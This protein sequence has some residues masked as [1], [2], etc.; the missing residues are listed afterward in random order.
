MR[1][2]AGTNLL[3]SYEPAIHILLVR[4]AHEVGTDVRMNFEAVS[5][6]DALLRERHHLHD[7]E[8]ELI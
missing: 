4:G 2:R 1:T 7:G 6:R 5:F 3:E 8:Q